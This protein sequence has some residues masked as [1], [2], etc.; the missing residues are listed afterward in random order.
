MLKSN[1]VKITACILVMMMMVPAGLVIMPANDQIIV[2]P[3]AEVVDDSVDTIV[4]Q[5]NATV[6]KDT[7]ISN[8][9]ALIDP[10]WNFG[11]DQSLY[12]GAVNTEPINGLIE[13]D[14]P[15]NV[16]NLNRAT[17]SLYSRSI[18]GTPGNLSVYGVSNDWEEGTGGAS[19]PAGIANWSYRLP[20]LVPWTTPGGDYIDTEDSYI[21]VT[22]LDTWYSWNVTSIVQNWKSGAW[23]N[24]GFFI[25]SENAPN[26]GT[27]YAAFHSTDYTVDTNLTPKLTLTYSAEIDPP[28]PPQTFTEDDPPRSIVL[29]NGNGSVVHVSGPDD[30]A[31]AQ[32]FFGTGADWLHFM[33]VYTPEQVGSE[34]VI[35]KIS[36]NRTNS[37]ETG[38]FNDVVISL[39]HTSQTDLVTTA[40]TDNHDGYLVEVFNEATVVLNSSDGDSWIHFDLNDNF[41]YDASHNLIVDIQWNGDDGNSLNMDS[42]NFGTIKSIW[43]SN[44]AP[45]TINTIQRTLVTR[46]TTDAMNNAII[47]DGRMGNGGLFDSADTY[48][49]FQ[50]L[51]NVTDMGNQSGIIDKIGFYKPNVGISSFP[52]FTISVAHSDNDTISS[53]FSHNYIGSLTDVYFNVNFT[54]NDSTGWV[55][56]DV[57]DK[58]DYDGVHNL[59]VQ[60]EWSGTAYGPVILLHR[61][62]PAA[63]PTNNYWART[64]I[65]GSLTGSTS[66]VYYNINILYHGS[67]NLTWSVI[68][69]TPD[70]VT[71]SVS[72]STLSIAP[73]ENAYGDATLT[74]TLTNAV[75]G[76][77][78]SQTID[79]TIV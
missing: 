46:F 70:K 34:G 37:V 14:L 6:G 61:G 77:S 18:V 22:Q 74:L 39:A 63:T 43:E 42:T 66:N 2:V 44:A 11:E 64:N 26:V 76:D 5:P 24:Y 35:R 32:P 51:Y 48:K 71:A 75:S 21:E 78:I 67:A 16:G 56:F 25:K 45:G 9:T 38:V 52:N 31:T 59:L 27:N 20:P 53:T 3:A 36:L 23:S 1:L 58:F 60:V 40:F 49:K 79:V 72:G 47:D 17:L 68:S 41:T 7:Y 15:A 13:F 30:I 33:G 50:I 54:H 28:V 73:V 4:I 12:I 69:N 8:D 62:P 29:D 55:E 10:S 57:D 19:G 65:Q